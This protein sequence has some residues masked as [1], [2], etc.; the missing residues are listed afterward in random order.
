MNPLKK[1]LTHGQ[2]CWMDD[3]TRHMIVSGELARRVA[4]EDLRGITSN[5]TIFEKAITSGSEYDSDIA[6]L[7]A[8]GRSPGEIYEELVTDD[9]RGACDILRPVYDQ[10]AGE[11]GY[12]SLEVSPHL[13]HDT[14]GSVAEARR[15]WARVGRPNVFIKIPG[16]V[17]GVPA[18][19]ELIFEGVNINITL[20][21][22][23]ESYEAVAQAY[24]RGLERRNAAG[25]PLSNVAS[26][27]SFFLSRIDTLADQLLQHRIVP[28][29]G[30]ISDPD[31]R[32]L[33]GHVA[34]ANAKLAYQAFKRILASGRWQ[35]VVAHGAHVQRMLWASTSTKNPA[36]HDLMYVEPL[37][38]SHTIN[39]MPRKTIAALLNHGVINATIEE[40][41]A[42]AEQVMADLSR[43]GI[44]F[45]LVTTQLENEGIQKFIEPYDA[46]LKSLATKREKHLPR[47]DLAPLRGMA[48]KLRRL[49]I[50]MTTA[51][52]SGHPTSCLSCADIMAALFF[53]EMRWDPSDPT[54]RNVDRFILSKGHAA[55]ILWA[56]LSEAHATS[57]D[58]MSLR[59]IDSTLEGHPTP[60]NPWIKVATGSLGQGLAAA[61]GI[62]LANRLDGID[63]RI[64]C[65]MGDGECSEG[66]VWEAAQ[67]ASLNRLT[68]LIAIVDVNGLG[69]SDPAPYRHDTSM[70][71]RRFAAF[72]WRAIEIDGHDMAAII[73]AL[74][75]AENSGPVAIVARTEKGKGVSFLEGATG[76]HG[77]TLDREQ[78]KKALAELGDADVNVTVEPRRA[79]QYQTRRA[80]QPLEI[81]PNYRRGELVATRQAFG[82]ALE[83]LGELDSEI[84][85]LDGDVKNSTGTGAFAKR[86]PDRFFESY[87][88]EQNMVGTALGLAAS[89]KIPFAATFAC[90]LSRAYDFIR[91]AQYSRPP[92]LV[93]CGS[94]AG[95]SIG[96]DGPSQMGLE[97]IAMFRALITSTVLYPC[98]A[99]SAERLTAAAAGAPGIVY[100]RTTRP[101]TAVIYDNDEEFPVG[102]SKTLRASPGDQLTLVAAGVTL[103]EALAAHESLS[104]KGVAVRVIDAYSIKPLDE[105]TLAR[106]A[107]ETGNLL[108]VEDHAIDG[109]LGDAVAAAVGSIAPVHHLGI[110]E[111]PRS[112][113]EKEL[114]DR[115]GISRGSIEAKVLALAA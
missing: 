104:K 24:L 75:Q 25:R 53:R 62:A 37:V 92:H 2:S 35:A 82:R 86:F 114:L 94:H 91:M 3:L 23:I 106:A 77:K 87:I 16:T 26:V 17:E 107:R 105:E 43:L 84:V 99:V 93:L 18:V 46:L 71:A 58:L 103:H 54:A 113:T 42:R 109:G 30:A 39:T 88:A 78:M 81:K 28:G 59:R 19:E 45:R 70:L 32:S 108:V 27:A 10:S 7:A 57:E 112:G 85:A 4:E 6:R 31:P 68:N 38:G 50:E 76:W 48:L 90:F 73:D 56:A 13:A 22:S 110:H 111:L 34:V 83:K 5:P 55:P 98:D 67:F 65:L 95:V 47:P 1:L 100:I 9:V 89:G 60:L 12:V 41:I 14:R 44:D 49:V 64:Y 33:L 101:K 97:D 15:L 40:S 66:S 21:F 79:G 52:G 51:A 61:N 8:A 96:E 20:L 36:Y 72:G 102:G 69:Q 115:H 74:H 29:S 11:D 63:A 80:A